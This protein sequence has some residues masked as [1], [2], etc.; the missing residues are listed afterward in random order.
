M[1]TTY[2]KTVA[3]DAIVRGV[4]SDQIFDAIESVAEGKRLWIKMH[5]A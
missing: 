3:T 5:I 1:I 2:V 4:V